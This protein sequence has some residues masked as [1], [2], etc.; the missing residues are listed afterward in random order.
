MNGRLNNSI[1]ARTFALGLLLQVAL[2]PSEHA[3]GPTGHRVVAEIAQRH[4][5]PA[6]QAKVSRL[7]GGRSL[8]D[9]ARSE[10][11]VVGIGPSV[12]GCDEAHRYETDPVRR[13][14]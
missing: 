8:A 14:G 3:W 7:L 4:L 2:V 12:A 6:V 13:F 9:V 10:Q 5:T 1:L 11:V